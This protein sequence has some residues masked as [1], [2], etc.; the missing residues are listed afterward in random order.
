MSNSFFERLEWEKF[1]Q[2]TLACLEEIH[3]RCCYY[4]KALKMMDLVYEVR[5]HLCVEIGVYGGASIYPTAS[6]I[7]CAGAGCYLYHKFLKAPAIERE[8]ESIVADSKD[9]A[10]PTS[11]FV[12]TKKDHNGACS[13]FHDIT[14]VYRTCAKSFSIDRIHGLV[15]KE[16]LKVRNKKYDVALLLAHGSP[17]SIVMDGSGF[18]FGLHAGRAKQTSFLS[19]RLKEG[20]KLIL[21]ACNTAQGE[22]N[23][24]K[25]LS[26]KIP[27]AIVYGSTAAV[28]ESNVEYAPDMTPTFKDGIL[29]QRNSTRAYKSGVLIRSQR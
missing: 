26:E 9:D 6:L 7:G 21:S 24:A 11:L 29:C 14:E 13:Y 12:H 8:I 23:L 3:P 19:N 5:P 28:S 18:F 2:K 16:T 1:K 22:D 25:G 20:G 27:H 10:K 15:Y 17:F 4:E